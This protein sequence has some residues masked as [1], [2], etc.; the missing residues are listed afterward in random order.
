MKILEIYNCFVKIVST[1]LEGKPTLEANFPR[2][3]Q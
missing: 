2:S 1:V 3:D